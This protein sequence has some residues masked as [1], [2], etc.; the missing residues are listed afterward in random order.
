[1]RDEYLYKRC[2]DRQTRDSIISGLLL[3]YPFLSK[4]MIGESRCGRPI[5][6][7]TVGAYRPQVLLCG[8]FHGMEWLTSTLLLRFLRDVC[9]EI[10]DG[11]TMYGISPRAIL[12]QRG[13][14]V[15]PCVNPDGVEIQLHGSECAYEYSDTVESC[16]G[17]TSHWQANAAGVDIN[18]N[19][20][21][22]WQ[23]LHNL[24][25]SSGITAPSPTRYGGEYPESEPESR[26]LASYCRAA[27]I[28]HA[29]AFHSQ[30]E[31]IYYSFGEH[32]SIRAREMGERLSLASGY[33]LSE[34]SG[35]AVGGGF[36]DWFIEKLRRPAFTVE[37]GK[38]ENPLPP[39]ML[40]DIYNRLREMMVISL[41]L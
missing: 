8:G 28:S 5:E 9:A 19:F 6:M 15:I 22:G 10:A 24:E 21:A 26:C 38:G 7:L 12:N 34:P 33:A 30:G 35:L 23:A 14:A 40:D 39:S 17:D 41:T 11:G 32:T 13:L 20:D 18:H 31:E 27:D 37:V 3:D 16:G 1:M 2:A 4:T 25:Q 29:L 36:K